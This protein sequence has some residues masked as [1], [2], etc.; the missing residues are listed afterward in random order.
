VNLDHTGFPVKL[1]RLADRRRPSVTVVVHRY[2]PV[3]HRRPF[4]APLTVDAAF[5]R[6]L[7]G[8]RSAVLKERPAI[9]SMYNNY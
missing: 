1:R 9:H 8:H 2:P 7:L 3:A 5:H 6:S 4:T